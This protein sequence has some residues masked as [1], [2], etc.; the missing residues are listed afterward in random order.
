MCDVQIRTYLSKC[1]KFFEAV[2]S[3]T[4]VPV[5]GGKDHKPGIKIQKDFGPTSIVA[6]IS[7]Q[8]AF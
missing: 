8:K 5:L 6:T 7:R 1:K 2:P 3:G 4:M